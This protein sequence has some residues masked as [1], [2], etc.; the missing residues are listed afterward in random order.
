[1]SGSSTTAG[2]S[3]RGLVAGV[4]AYAIW[5]LLP[6][7]FPLLAPAAAIEIIGH[8]VVWSLGFCLALLVVTRTWPQYVAALRSRRTLGV[9]ATAAALI[10]VNWT[11]YVY[12]VLA[13]RVVEAALGYFINPLVTVLLA[14]V[15]LRERLRTLQWV[16]LGF[17]AA[18]VVVIGA[19]NNGVP[20]ISLTLAFTFGTYGLIKNRIGRSIGAITGLAVETTVLFPAA[21]AYLVWLQVRGAAAFGAHG[22]GH[23]ALLVAAGVITATPLLLFSS[24]ARR[25][26]LSMIGLLQ[27]LTPTMQFLLGVVY[28]HEHMPTAR[29]VGFALV[30]V[31]LVVSSVD[32][33]RRATQGMLLERR[34]Q[35]GGAPDAN[36]ITE[37]GVRHDIN[38]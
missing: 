13:D 30:W 21:L 5:G 22:L 20:W 14:V 15:V 36:L 17:G 16:A 24:A 18:A 27:Y 12:A 34:G 38:G 1:M 35:L 37:A 32:G 2:S 8:R 29:W 3:R 10:A 4:G 33:L 25:I 19:S 31:A 28:F 23:T 11:V 9:L 6:L 26:P 7:Y